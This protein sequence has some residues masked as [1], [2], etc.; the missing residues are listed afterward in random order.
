MTNEEPWYMKVEREAAEKVEALLKL[1]IDELQLMST[2]ESFDPWSLFP[3]LY[4]TYSSDFDKCAIEVLTELIEKEKNRR[5]L[6]AEM[7]REMLCTAYL[8]NYGSSPRV[9]FPTER[10][11]P[12]I[13]PLIEKWRAY[14]LV[15]W[16]LDVCATGEGK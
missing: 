13:Q 2:G 11:K 1:P 5:D 12:L 15:I 10:F 9:C 4:G 16:G 3:C 14:A 7:F 6:G 8:C